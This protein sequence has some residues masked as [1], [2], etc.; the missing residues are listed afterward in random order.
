[1]SNLLQH[2]SLYDPFSLTLFKDIDRSFR[3]VF[4]HWPLSS[5][6]ESSL[7]NFKTKET[8]KA[9]I[10]SLDIPGV[11]ESDLSIE[12]DNNIL[13]IEGKR[14][15][16]LDG[17]ERLEKF[18]RNFT[19]PENI[20]KKDIKAHCEHGVLFLALPKKAESTRKKISISRG[21]DK[22]WKNFFSLM[23]KSGE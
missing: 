7:I 10:L 4:S 5:V 9:Y 20:S 8:E 23:D 14:S 6:S 15:H 13:R 2:R 3:D 22:D 21:K 16:S 11:K 1:M 12:L 18:G 17:A 19:I